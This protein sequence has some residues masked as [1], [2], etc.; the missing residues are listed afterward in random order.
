M[1]KLPLGR[2][3]AG[4]GAG[5]G[6]ACADGCSA[7]G[8][9]GASRNCVAVSA[10]ARHFPVRAAAILAVRPA[11][12]ATALGRTIAVR[13][14]LTFQ[15]L[16]FLEKKQVLSPGKD[17]GRGSCLRV[18]GWSSTARP[19]LRSAPRSAGCT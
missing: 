3:G 18:R 9:G 2:A 7:A 13:R 4:A 5:G 12:Y 15:N 17:R 14:L 19:A 8:R 1:M 16:E 10:I 11:S 6:V